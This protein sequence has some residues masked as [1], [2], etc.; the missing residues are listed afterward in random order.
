MSE[1]KDTSNLGHYLSFSGTVPVIPPGVAE[2]LAQAQRN[3][4]K[5]LTDAELRV[6]AELR[7]EL[8]DWLRAGEEMLRNL[9]QRLGLE[10]KP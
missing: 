5:E 6:D 3:E 4:G 7:D 2:G 1:L 8:A 9:E 10:D